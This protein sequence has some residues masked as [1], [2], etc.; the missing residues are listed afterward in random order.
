MERKGGGARPLR[1]VNPI[2]HHN[3]ETRRRFESVFRRYTASHREDARFRCTPQRARMTCPSAMPTCRQPSLEWICEVRWRHHMGSPFK[4]SDTVR[5]VGEGG[6]RAL[7]LERVSISLASDFLSYA[8]RNGE[9][10][11]MGRQKKGGKTQRRNQKRG[12]ENKARRG[13]PRRTLTNTRECTR[14]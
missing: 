12:R 8:V 14:G 2:R 5:C 9:H 13:P 6:G 7:A 1:E 10:E 4:E 3:R 11:K